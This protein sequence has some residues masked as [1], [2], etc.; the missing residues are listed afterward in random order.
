M[1]AY[2]AQLKAEMLPA[3]TYGAEQIR[4]MLERSD[5]TPPRPEFA[6]FAHKGTETGCRGYASVPF[7]SLEDIQ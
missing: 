4:F 7:R 3:T 1:Q 5:A 6:A 2:A